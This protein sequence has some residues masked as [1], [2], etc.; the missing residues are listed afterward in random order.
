M[1]KRT[2]ITCMGEIRHA[3]KILVENVNGR[4]DLVGLG[5]DGMVIL[6]LILNKLG[7]RMWSGFT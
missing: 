5:L 1:Y 7:G 6:K 2:S 3:H 4:Y